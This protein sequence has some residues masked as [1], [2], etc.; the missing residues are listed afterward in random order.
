ML[1]VANSS[2]LVALA[3]CQAL[4]LLSELFG[5]VIVPRTV[6]DEVTV[7]DKPQA[8][9]LAESLADRVVEVDTDRFVLAAGGLG[10]GEIEAMVLYKA[11]SADYLLIDDRRARTIAEANDIRCVGTP[12]SKFGLHAARVNTEKKPTD[13]V[14]GET[15]HFLLAAGCRR[16]DDTLHLLA[17]N[18]V[19]QS[20]PALSIPV[21][22][23]KTTYR[24]NRHI[25]TTISGPNRRQFVSI[26]LSRAGRRLKPD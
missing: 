18:S 2:A 1:I 17:Q 15:S 6:F 16:Y 3:T 20:A 11:S 12:F 4:Q 10:Q 9:S 24:S 22:T 23:K 5:D 14:E 25:Y 7:A 8:N 19:T 13:V 21:K 26:F